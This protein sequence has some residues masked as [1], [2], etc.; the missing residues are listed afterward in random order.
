MLEMPVPI[1]SDA[2]PVLSTSKIKK[3]NE[4]VRDPLESMGTEVLLNKLA[5][6]FDISDLRTYLDE[7]NKKDSLP[8]NKVVNENS[9]KKHD[10]IEKKKEKFH[11]NERLKNVRH[12]DKTK[13]ELKMRKECKKINEKKINSTDENNSI[14]S[15]PKKVSFKANYNTQKERTY[16]NKS[17]NSY[18]GDF[19]NVC[20]KDIS[21]S[22]VCYVSVSKD[23]SFSD[24][25]EVKILQHGRSRTRQHRRDSN[26][27]HTY[28]HG[29]HVSKYLSRKSCNEN[30]KYL[31]SPYSRENSPNYRYNKSPNSK[32]H[33]TGG[34]IR[35]ERGMKSTGNYSEVHR[36][37]PHKQYR[38]NSPTSSNNHARKYISR[39]DAFISCD[40]DEQ[41]DHLN[42]NPMGG[43]EHLSNRY[44]DSRRHRINS[45]QIK[46]RRDT[47]YSNIDTNHQKPFDKF[48][49]YG[50]DVDSNMN[51]SCSTNSEPLIEYIRRYQKKL[52]IAHDE[53]YIS[54]NSDNYG[55]AINDAGDRH[56]KQF[57]GKGRIPVNSPQEMY[58]VNEDECVARMLKEIDKGTWRQRSGG[59][60]CE[61]EVYSKH[62]KCQE[63]V[64]DDY[65]ERRRLEKENLLHKYKVD[66]DDLEVLTRLNR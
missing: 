40:C 19:G 12:C 33:Y 14:L 29:K 49:D 1:K 20:V 58:P 4:S 44:D 9:S 13:H 36:V 54:S 34:C 5:E 16:K 43:H 32:Q 47:Y 28:R 38:R 65:D 60:E 2:I 51:P 48:D 11:D 50:N 66:D 7:Q 31:N 25:S 64:H 56:R 55:M 52:N 46:S 27:I 39:E 17:C 37:K 61:F 35:E 3:V 22:E 23:E 6:K 10:N 18:I 62:P 42:R 57:G 59:E 45:D 53:E 15:S 63:T 26:E 8:D 30:E 24:H 21:Y 41:G